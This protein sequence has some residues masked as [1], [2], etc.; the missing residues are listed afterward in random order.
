[1]RHALT[2]SPAAPAA[3]DTRCTAADVKAERRS[4]E[5]LGLDTGEDQ[6]TLPKAGTTATT[7]QD[8]VH[9]ADERSWRSS[10]GPG[11]SVRRAAS[12]TVARRRGEEQASGDRRRPAMRA[13]LVPCREP[14]RWVINRFT[15]VEF[16][17]RWD[18]DVGSPR[19]EFLVGN[20]PSRV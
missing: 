4:P 1:M 16:T 17:W 8:H 20:M 18:V 3:S 12:S 19:D 7:P 2:V 6:R 9:N 5:G 11:R 10:L 14:R 13:P 15:A